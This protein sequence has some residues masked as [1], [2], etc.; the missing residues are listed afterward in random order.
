MKPNDNTKAAPAKAGLDDI[1]PE[2]DYVLIRGWMALPKAEAESAVQTAKAH[3]LDGVYAVRL[4]DAIATPTL[5]AER[6]ALREACANVLHI[7]DMRTTLALPQGSLFEYVR[8]HPAHEP[9]FC[10]W[11]Q[12]R[13]SLRTALALGD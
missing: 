7:L 1:A 11:Q 13:D 9:I 12:C 5:L 2:D 10:E 8:Q 4:A 3:G 6:D